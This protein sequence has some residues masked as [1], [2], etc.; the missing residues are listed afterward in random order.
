MSLKKDQFK[1]NINIFQD[2]GD[3]SCYMVIH[4]QTKSKT[5]FNRTTA[6]QTISTYLPIYIY[7]RRQKKCEVV[8][9]IQ[10][11]N[12]FTNCVETFLDSPIHKSIVILT[13]SSAH[14]TPILCQCHNLGTESTLRVRKVIQHQCATCSAMQ[15][16]NSRNLSF[17]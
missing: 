7:G 10:N 5:I 6:F 2:N 13:K 8:C 17:D 3:L 11:T 16:M 14:L 9:I 12:P 15:V 4:H 1:E